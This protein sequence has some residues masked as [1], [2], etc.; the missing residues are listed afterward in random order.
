MWKAAYYWKQ[1][2]ACLAIAR[3][4]KDRGKAAQ[5]ALAADR[6]FRKAEQVLRETMMHP[7][8]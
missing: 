3:V 2:Q 1:A 8:Q 5:Y 4:L 6:Y 7:A